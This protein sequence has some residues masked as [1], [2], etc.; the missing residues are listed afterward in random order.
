ME[1]MN[2]TKRR[3]EIFNILQKE[4]SVKVLD[5]AE[6]FEVSLMTIRRDLALFEKQGLI[7]TNYGGAY[8][9]SKSAIEPSF[10]LKSSQMTDKKQLIGY[11]AAKLVEE[12]DTIIVDCGTTTLQMV[13]YIQDKKLTV[14]TN[15]WP[16]V[17]YLGNNPKIKLILA[18]GEYNDVS[19][20]AI[21]DLTISFFSN[22]HADKVFMGSH[23]CGLKSG[24]TVPEIMDANVKRTILHAA[25]Q[26][27][28]LADNTKF[29]QTYLMKY[30]DL[31]EF[32]YLITDNSIDNKYCIQLKNIIKNVII[33]GNEDSIE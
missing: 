5:L 32:D 2:S 17:N 7:T 13:K 3:M 33:A 8:L 28:L 22:F 11:E 24:A 25:K 19:A 1:K 16:V 9:N 29:D 10:S 21:S 12:G 26:K 30:A 20:G 27:I 14:I 23:G 18:P 6:I 15:S 31:S 4:Q